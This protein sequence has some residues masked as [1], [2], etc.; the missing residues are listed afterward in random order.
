MHQIPKHKC[1]L[2]CLAV[3][4]AQPIEAMCSVENADVVGAAPTGDAPNNLC[5]KINNFI[6][7]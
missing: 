7:Y 6:A 4:S 2:F 5:D 1:F 3:V